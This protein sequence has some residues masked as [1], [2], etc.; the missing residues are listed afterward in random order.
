MF[1]CFAYGGKFEVVECGSASHNRRENPSAIH[2]PFFIRD[3]GKPFSV[4]R[5]LTVRGEQDRTKRFQ[6]LKG[7]LGGLH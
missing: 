6:S 2:R 5:I 1:A 3:V 7:Q 4:S